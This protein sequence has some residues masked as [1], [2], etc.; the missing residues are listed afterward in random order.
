MSAVCFYKL[1]RGF[2]RA[3][4]LSVIA[5]I[6]KSAMRSLGELVVSARS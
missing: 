1:Y 4:S 5:S 3:I 2:K 6:L